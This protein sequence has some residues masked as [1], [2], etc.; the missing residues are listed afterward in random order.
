LKKILL[1]LIILIFSLNVCGIWYPPEWT[2]PEIP[3]LSFPIDMCQTISSSGNYHLTTDL[4]ATPGN[5][6]IVIESSNVSL[7][8]NDY[9]ITG[10][11]ESSTFGIKAIGTDRE[12]IT[13]QNCEISDFG[14]NIILQKVT[15]AKVHNNSTGSSVNGTSI[16]IQFSDNSE[17]TEN[18]VLGG[19][20][21]VQN[22]DNALVLKN[23]VSNPGSSGIYIAS[24]KNNSITENTINSSN[25]ALQLFETTGNRIEENTFNSSDRGIYISRAGWPTNE[26]NI[27]KNNILSAPKKIFVH[28]EGKIEIYDTQ[29]TESDIYQ[30]ADWPGSVKV[31]FSTEILVED[32][33][34]NPIE[35]A[36]VT[37]TG[38]KDGD[39]FSGT[40]NASGKTTKIEFLGFDEDETNNPVN[41]TVNADGF[42][43]K[44]ENKSF[45]K[46][47]NH[48]I[49]LTR[50]SD[51]SISLNSPS[52]N[53]WT[54]LKE[55]NFSFTPNDPN[56]ITECKYL[57]NEIAWTEKDSFLGIPSNT[58]HEFNYTFSDDG[59]YLW[60]IWCKN[61]YS[62]EYWSEEYS[63]NIDSVLPIIDY[64][65]LTQA[66]NSE[67]TETEILI[68]VEVT[69]LN[70]N[71]VEL[72]LNGSIEGTL[73]HLS[74]NKYSKTISLNSGINQFKVKAIDL[75]GN[76]ASTSIRKV[77][78]IE[79]T[80]SSST[81]TSE[82]PEEKRV[83]PEELIEEQTTET[84]EENPETIQ[85]ESIE[86][87]ESNAS[88]EETD[89]IIETQENNSFLMIL[90]GVIVLLIVAGG[91]FYLI[92]M[93]PKTI[94]KSEK[95]ENSELKEENNSKEN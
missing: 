45:N 39:F 60:K 83:E 68:E 93:K 7:N 28:D 26:T 59:S 43:E 22:S 67:V 9:S 25:I 19:I 15:G 90:I 66:N 71:K 18:T 44:T 61:N 4:T 54:N 38:V 42:E 3:E 30:S 95:Q 8:C 75:A 13:I 52:N 57:N 37:L 34:G 50:V 1:I 74:G 84:L 85:E 73:N 51:E 46:N 27:A 82:E 40:T 11:N 91:A 16:F 86:S 94:N 31:Y 55:V 88:E 33:L 78:L 49:I 62:H 77:T 80:E 56:T 72:E 41:I 64:T 29:L 10:N 92:K 14:I 65:T 5:S 79:E 12:N 32:E 36:E 89:L 20:L 6:C 21:Y 70:L 47:E 48:T 87:N 17:I 76:T 35:N 81:E 23:T 53:S 2:P 69:E 24:S 63:I 58:V